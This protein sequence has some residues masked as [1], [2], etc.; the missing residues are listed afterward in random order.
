VRSGLWSSEELVLCKRE[1]EK[2]RENRDSKTL[3]IINSPNSHSYC[4]ACGM[5]RSTKIKLQI[6][7]AKPLNVKWLCLMDFKRLVVVVFVVVVVV[8]TKEIV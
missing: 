4:G 5:M 1:R 2:E 8:A 6:L 3:M 7:I